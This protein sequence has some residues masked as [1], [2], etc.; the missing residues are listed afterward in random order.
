[1]RALLL[2]LWRSSTQRVMSLTFAGKLAGLLADVLLAA[3]L[4]TGQTA[5]ALFIALGFPLFVDTV[6]RESAKFSLVPIFV[7]YRNQRPNRYH[8]FVS[9][10][11]NA[12]L[13]GGAVLLLV[14]GVGAH[15]IVRGLGPG[16]SAEGITQATHLLWMCAPLLLFAPV[17]TIQGV[18]LNSEKRFSRV[19]LRSAVTP[20]IV[21]VTLLATWNQ[22]GAATWAAGGYSA[23]FAVYFAFLATGIWRNAELQYK[24]NAW[25]T[26]KDIVE[27][28]AALSWPS[29]GFVVRQVA[30][31]LERTIASLVMVG[32]VSSYYFASRIYSGV[33]SV[34][35]TSIATTGL[36]NLSLQSTKGDREEAQQQ[37]RKQTFQV[38]L[39]TV[40]AAAVLLLFNETII[41]LIYG[42]G[43]FGTKAIQRTTGLLFWF[44]PGILF[45]C[46]IP[47]LST[48]LY[49]LRQYRYVF[50][51]MVAMAGLNLA[52]AWGLARTAGFGLQGIA[53]AVSL[54]ALCGAISLAFLIR[55]A[56]L[57]L[58]ASL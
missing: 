42:R 31:L 11:L 26:S 10:L 8:R 30:R 53:A 9:G 40:P 32:G 4:G 17:I 6:T 14:A 35:G 28:R 39:L 50:W 37:V 18:L 3:R 48:V 36:P 33:Q 47:T 16:M 25:P 29:M 34:I 5:D 24:W 19:A 22:P 55:K 43:E 56:G 45:S 49:S 23:G 20:G 58:S 46:L 52:L 21:A 44:G 1:M 7:Q 38:V 27:I 12:S 51:N 13:A 41:D 15:W 57:P 2:R 54:T